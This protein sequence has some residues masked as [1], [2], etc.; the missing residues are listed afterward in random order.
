MEIKVSVKGF[1]ELREHIDRLLLDLPKERAAIICLDGRCASGKS[2][3]AKRLAEAY[4]CN[5]FHTDDFFL[6]TEQRTP[7]RYA[8]P[9]GNLDYERMRAEVFEKIRQGQPFSYRPF[10]C[11]VMALAEAVEVESAK[12]NL[13]EGSYSHHP[14]FQDYCDLKIF[15]VVD[16]YTQAKRLLDREGAEGYKIF[17]DRWIP[18]EEKYFTKLKIREN[19][20]IIYLENG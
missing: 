9:G 3:L 13:I 16:P 20:D 15:M 18:L 4:S 1:L 5:L 14:A 10:D 12:L 2:T 7:E 6:R 17:V 19:S 8:E 11:S